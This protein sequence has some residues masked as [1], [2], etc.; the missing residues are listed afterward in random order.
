MLVSGLLQKGLGKIAKGA[1]LLSKPRVEANTKLISQFSSSTIDEAVKYVM[2]NKNI[3]IFDK[4]A[5]NLDMLV[6]ALGS[7][8]NT[9]R[10]ILEAAN[11]K[12]PAKGI[13][14]NIPIKLVIILLLLKAWYMKEFQ[15]YYVYY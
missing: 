11:G 5:H 12:L 6:N 10:A 2:K 1:K 9:I 4:S 8:E 7:R 14:E 13:F 3:H 15:T